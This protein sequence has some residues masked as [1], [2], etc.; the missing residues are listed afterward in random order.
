MTALDI[1]V[2]LLVGGGAFAGFRRGF[3]HEMLSLA[4]WVAGV[5]AVKTFHT[6]AT[7]ALAP[8]VGT[9][10][11]A[12]ALA[13]VLTFGIAFIVVKLL[14]A[15]IGGATRRSI[16]G[17][18]DRILGGGFGLLKGLIVASLLFLLATTLTGFSRIGERARPDWLTGARTYPLLNA[19]SRALVDFVERRRNAP[20]KSDA[21]LNA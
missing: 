15:R 1:L 18:I 19:T 3:V 5:V 17:P 2:L 4:A 21:E 6:P 14:A 12:A 8:F 13:L 20:T 16:V 10:T 9:A 7:Q 11:G